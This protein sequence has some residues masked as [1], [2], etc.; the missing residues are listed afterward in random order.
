MKKKGSPATGSAKRRSIRVH[1][2]P[3]AEI[4]S[5]AELSG[6]NFSQW[7]IMLL[8]KEARKLKRKRKQKHA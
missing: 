1:D 4:Q 5:G 3:W 6:Y 8:L 2:E 7:A